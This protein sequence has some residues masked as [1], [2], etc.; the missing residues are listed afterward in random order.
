MSKEVVQR[1]YADHLDYLEHLPL[2]VL[3]AIDGTSQV[4]QSLE[5]QDLEGELE[6]LNILETP[7]YDR[8]Q[9]IQAT[10][11]E[12][13]YNV[14]TSRQDKIGYA[15]YRDGGVPRT[16]EVEVARRRTLPTL[17]GHRITITE[18][19]VAT[20]RAGVQTAEQTARTEKMVAVMEET[21]Y[22]LFHGDRR[23]GST[24]FSSPQN[25]QFD[26][27]ENIVKRGAPQNVTDLGGRPLSLNA[28][29]AAEN[30]VYLTQGL[31]RPNVVMMSP[32]DKI[33]LQQSFYQIAR[34]TQADRVAGVLG[35]DAQTYISAYGET[36][37]VTDRFLGDWHKFTDQ[38]F[39]NTG[40]EFARPAAPSAVTLTA[41]ANAAGNAG[42]E[43][44]EYNYMVK[45]ANFNGESEAVEA[46][47][48]VTPTAGQQ[49]Q[50]AVATVPAG[51]KWLIVYRSDAGGDFKF[52]KKV[53]VYA[54]GTVNVVDDGHET[55]VSAYGTFTY[56]KVPGTGFVVGV[57][58]MTT[59]LAQWIPL[60]Q[61]PLPQTL[62]RDF[63][64]RHVSS[65]FSRAPE[66]NFLIVNVAQEN[67]I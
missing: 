21:E 56:R 33:N 58:L 50:L 18:L 5:R 49:I 29:W 15:A 24:D 57:D 46:G 62:N 2:D 52:L 12:H 28:L 47:A 38:G 67:V 16:V 64:I 6:R 3:K 10:A 41:Q 11:Y 22:L 48:P 26:G 30:K 40:G 65:L 63:A 32:V 44:I 31:A 27:L 37:L 43:A 60:E 25:L 54:G 14:V 42:L 66:F 39:G 35:T 20:T 55:L 53:P 45:A 9:K 13:E 1:N 36:E 19:A 51:A 23:F 8:L 34:T 61:V 4:A 17:L 7:F 59:M